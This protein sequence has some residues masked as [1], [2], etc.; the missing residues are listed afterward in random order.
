[1]ASN[2]TDQ[3]NNIVTDL[4]APKQVVST[5]S[6]TGV[7]NSIETKNRKWHSKGRCING[8]KIN[9]LFSNSR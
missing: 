1:M 8:Q 5:V 4:S 2:N 3:N 6:S 9:A 7:N